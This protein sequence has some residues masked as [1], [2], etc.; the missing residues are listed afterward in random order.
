MWRSQD[1]VSH[2][3]T[4]IAK[5]RPL[6]D[7]P[8]RP[9]AARARKHLM[10]HRKLDKY[11]RAACVIGLMGLAAC[12]KVPVSIVAPSAEPTTQESRNYLQFVRE[13]RG[14]FF[15][16][17]RDVETVDISAKMYA[18]AIAIRADEYAVMWEAARTCAWLGN[19]GPEDTRKAYV[20][21]GLKYVNTAVKLNPEGEEGLFF[22]GAL[23]GKLADL[24]FTYGA[25]GAKIIESRMHQ[26]IDN[27]STYL[28]GGPDRLLAALYMRAPGKPL[29]VGSYE[30]AL[31]HMNRALYLEPHWP[32]NQLY[33]AELEFRLG[34][35]EKDA[36]LTQSARQRLQEYFFDPAR[37]PPMAMASEFEFAELQKDARK[38]LDDYE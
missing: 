18:A 38:L 36:A 10:L 19:F 31:R 1:V 5:W 3:W 9:P 33:M 22:H 21:R 6:R 32:E 25:D 24:D 16:E 4:S 28:Y 35:K 27:G 26:L 7:S 13:G 8:N 29:S 2:S 37:K 30:K 11:L 23:A 14:A 34:A 15:K 12:S 20:Q 17:P